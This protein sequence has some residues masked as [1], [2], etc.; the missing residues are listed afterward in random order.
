MGGGDYVTKNPKKINEQK[1]VQREKK[2]QNW[3]HT[4]FFNHHNKNQTGDEIS[5]M[6]SYR[7]Y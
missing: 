4:T 6:I 2:I 1:S 3:L 5:R 7:V